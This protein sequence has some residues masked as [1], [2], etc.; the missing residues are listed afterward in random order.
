MANNNGNQ[1]RDDEIVVLTEN[2]DGKMV[3][4][5]HPKIGGRLR[6]AQ[7]GHPRTALSLDFDQLRL[8]VDRAEEEALKARKEREL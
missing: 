3:G 6:P 8:F 4:S 5:I 1:L 7:K 2:R